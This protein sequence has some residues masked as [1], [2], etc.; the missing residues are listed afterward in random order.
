MHW[1]GSRQGEGR[2]RGRRRGSRRGREA[3]AGLAV[4]AVFVATCSAACGSSSAGCARDSDC[5]AGRVCDDGLCRALVDLDTGRRDASMI[6]DAMT[7][8]GGGACSVSAQDCAAGFECVGPC[9]GLGTCA[10]VAACPVSPAPECGCDGRTYRDPCTRALAGA[11]LAHAGWCACGECGAGTF[12][13]RGLGCDAAAPGVCERVPSA[14]ADDGS[15]AVGPCPSDTTSYPNDCARRA[16]GVESGEMPPACG[17]TMLR[18]GCCWDDADCTRAGARCYGVVACDGTQSSDLLGACLDTTTLTAAGCYATRDCPPGE[19]CAGAT[20]C[21]CATIMDA[22]CTVV[23]GA[24]V[25][26]ESG[27]F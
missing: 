17:N 13:N 16:A 1:S 12:C 2:F 18:A 10:R 11:G 8:D 19:E 3:P 25:P 20:L 22:S 27:L 23:T 14:C 26:R 9:D 5:R 4:L 21:T 24:C 15:G 7:G 6:S